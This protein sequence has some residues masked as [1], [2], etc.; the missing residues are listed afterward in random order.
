[1]RLG[2]FNGAVSVTLAATDNSGGSGVSQIRY[3]T[4]GT[5]PTATTGTV[6]TG[7]FTVSAST[8]TVKYRAFDNAG[9]AEATNSQLMQIDTVA[10]SSTI[11]CNGT[12]CAAGFYT[13]AV[14]VTLTASD[15]GG[16]GV[17]QIVYTTDGSDPDAVERHR[18]YGRVH[19]LRDDDRQVPRLRH[20]PATPSRSTRR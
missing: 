1:M 5:T 12:T 6:Y 15:V 19:A 20:T 3:T 7:A 10:P 18:L 16:S 4:N 11:H 9:N 2:W 17:A 8:T 14:S 13:A